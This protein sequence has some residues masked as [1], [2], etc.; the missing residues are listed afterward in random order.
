MRACACVG[1]CVCVCLC[2][3]LCVRAYVCA[4][5]LAF[6]RSCEHM[7]MSITVCLC[8]CASRH[9]YCA[10]MCARVA[11]HSG[12]TRQSDKC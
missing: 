3:G 11:E 12:R 9:C 7:C 1:E 5:T 2:V 10:P 6:I 4:P 8:V